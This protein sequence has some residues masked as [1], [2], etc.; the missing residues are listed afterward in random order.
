MGPKAFE[1]VLVATILV[2]LLLTPRVLVAND[3][4][5]PAPDWFRSDVA[6][7]GQGLHHQSREIQAL[8]WLVWGSPTDPARHVVQWAWEHNCELGVVY[9]A[10]PVE[11]EREEPEEIT[12]RDE[13]KPEPRVTREPERTSTPEPRR[14]LSRGRDRGWH[15]HGDIYHQHFEGGDCDHGHRVETSAVTDYDGPGRYGYPPC[16]VG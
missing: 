15:Y 5:V 6:V 7:D 13:P 8:F 9:E 16:P 10:E 3:C 14:P 12:S 11:S 2:G 4:G 1:R